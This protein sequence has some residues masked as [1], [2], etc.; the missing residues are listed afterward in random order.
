MNAYLSAPNTQKS[1]FD[2]LRSSKVEEVKTTQKRIKSLDDYINGLIAKAVNPKTS[3]AVALRCDEQANEALESQ[4]QHKARLVEL[5][6]M[7]S[8][9]YEIEAAF[10]AKTECLTV[11]D[12]FKSYA[13]ARE[14]VGLFVEKI[15]VDDTNDDIEI[16]FKD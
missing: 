3:K 16:M 11:D 14:I 8:H 9:V 15:V 2:L 4:A 6:E 12:I 1:V 5:Q 7:L 13:I 10:A